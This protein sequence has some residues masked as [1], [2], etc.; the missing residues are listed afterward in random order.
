MNNSL[1]LY[2]LYL[3]LLV[4]QKLLEEKVSWFVTTGKFFLL[5]FPI[6]AQINK[7]RLLRLWKKMI[8]KAKR[9]RSFT[10][11]EQQNH[12]CT[13][14]YV[15]EI[16]TELWIITMQLSI[17]IANKERIEQNFQFRHFQHKNFATAL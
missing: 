9:F 15:L 11:R 3:H 2:L 13:F 4:F 16:L 12:L 7:N 5:Y 8:S 14:W 6:L 1:Q 17:L 10:Q